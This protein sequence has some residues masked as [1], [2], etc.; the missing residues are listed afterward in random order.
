[1]IYKLKGSVQTGLPAIE[2]VLFN[3]GIA[4]SNMRH[5]LNTTWADVN[6]PLALGEKN[7][8]AAAAALIT[9]VR[10]NQKA[11]IIVD[12]DCD[13]F[14]SSAILIN[15]LYDL[16]PSWVKEKVQW[17][18][19]EGKEHGLSDFCKGN[20]EEYGLVF[21]P[22]AG[23]NDYEYHLEFAAQ[24]TP[25]IILDHHEAEI[26]SPNA[27]VINNQ[28]CD[29]PNKQLS[30]AGV[31]WQFCRYLDLVTKNNYANQYLDLVALGNMAD[32]MDLR[33]CE[34]KQLITEGFKDTNLK[35]PFIYGMAKKNAY[36]LGNKVT[37]MGAA[38]YIAPLVNATVRS[39]TIQEKELL[40]K[41]ML[42]FYAFEKI[43]STK[44]GHYQGEEE[45]L[46]EQALRTVT[47]VKNRQT[48]IQ[49][50]AIEKL[51]KRIKDEN[52]LNHKVLLFLLEENEVDKNVA[53]L[54]ANKL[55]AKYQRPCCVLMKKIKKYPKIYY[56]ENGDEITDCINIVQ[57]EGSA[58]GCDLAGVSQ[59]K[60]ICEHAPGV[61]YAQGHQ[62]AFGLGICALLV[63]EFLN[64][65]DD[66]LK[67]MSDE[68]V[69]YVDFIYDGY[70]VQGQ[71]ILSIANYAELWG[72]GMPEPYIAIKNLKVTKEM[73]TIYVKKNNTMKISLPNG[74]SIMLFNASDEICDKLQNQNPGYYVLDIVG[75]CNANEWCGKVT[76][77]VFI[78]NYN[79]VGQ[80]KYSF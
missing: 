71:D 52:L 25:V 75:K 17:F 50:A 33:E 11:I 68:P 53:G 4:Q 41:S 57:Y 1:M 76:P 47:N 6:S 79:I 56:D 54:I 72:T 48:K 34:T 60:D 43:L 32:M 13:G 21:V 59:F 45:Q 73:V 18:I 39:G 38:F 44:R 5:Y 8:K 2:Q 64:Y 12:S 36:S 23:S 27:I 40:F 51:E 67:D 80:Q 31:T 62:G 61:E 66:V 70:N 35:N 30:G 78:E 77:Q 24:G 3:R 14:T 49:D 20:E 26:T 65:T 16:F 10:D 63:E 42:K 7:L 74:L 29:Y 69:Y 55:M 46:I 19:H 28:L 58:R 9:C 15:Y 37:P 22:D